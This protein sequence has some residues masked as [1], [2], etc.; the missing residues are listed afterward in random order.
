[1]VRFVLALAI[2]LL[3]LP[4]FA[5]DVVLKPVASLGFTTASAMLHWYMVSPD[6]RVV[7]CE[8]A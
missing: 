7:V 1:M 6:G 2:S 5:A 8:D 4:A 3:A